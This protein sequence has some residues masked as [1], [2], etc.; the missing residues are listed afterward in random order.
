[1]RLAAP[2]PAFVTGFSRLA[3]GEIVSAPLPSYN[4]PMEIWDIWYP[5]AGAQG[6]SFSRSRIEYTDRVWV[7]AAP[8]TLRIE[9]RSDDGARLAFGDQLRRQGAYFPMT[10]LTRDG[11]HITRE[12]RWPKA[13]DLGIP[14]LLP[15]GEAG[16]LKAWWN[17]DDG[18]EWRWSVEFYN[19]RP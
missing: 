19:S 13:S 16:I 4:H 6:L 3:D 7:H 11:S 5:D 12:D 10:F 1:M 8:H 17:D 9:V 14:V 18:Q 2:G 15:G